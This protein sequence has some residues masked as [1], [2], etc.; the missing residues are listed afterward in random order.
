MSIVPSLIFFNAVVEIGQLIFVSIVLLL[1]WVVNKIVSQDLFCKAEM[2]IA[3]AIGTIA[4]FWLIERTYG[5]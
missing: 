2:M 5:F 3:Y 4:T 1:T